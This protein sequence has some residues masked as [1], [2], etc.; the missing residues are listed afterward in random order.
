[1]Q[2]PEL[3][4]VY[5][6]STDERQRK[7][8]ANLRK[9]DQELTEHRANPLSLIMVN[10]EESEKCKQKMFGLSHVAGLAVSKKSRKMSRL[11]PQRFDCTGTSST[12]VT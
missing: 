5:T 4:R 12:Y 6:V 9:E 2:R 3:S 11:K 7:L 10:W 1:M 8:S